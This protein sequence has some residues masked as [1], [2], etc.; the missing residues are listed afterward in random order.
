[1]LGKTESVFGQMPDETLEEDRKS[2]KQNRMP[3]GDAQRQNVGSHRVKQSVETNC[4]SLRL[5]SVTLRP[6]AAA[7]ARMAGATSVGHDHGHIALPA[8]SLNFGGAG[9]VRR[10]EVRFASSSA[11][12][13]TSLCYCC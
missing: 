8:D 13:M 11:N 2:T 12:G 6:A 1:M 7:G 3:L 9:F 5:P 4:A 10:P